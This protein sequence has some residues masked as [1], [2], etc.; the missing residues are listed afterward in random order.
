MAESSGWPLSADGGRFEE[1]TARWD[2]STLRSRAPAG[3]AIQS[4]FPVIVV[5]HCRRSQPCFLADV[6]LPYRIAQR[7]ILPP[8]QPD[9]TSGSGSAE[10]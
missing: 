7:R 9:D 8:H 2:K 1:I 4:G 10:R 3:R 6:L 5:R